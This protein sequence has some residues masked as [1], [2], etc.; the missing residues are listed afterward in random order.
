VDKVVDGTLLERSCGRSAPGTKLWMERSRKK[1]WTKC[2][3]KKLWMEHS[4]KR[5]WM[6][7]EVVEGA[8]G[9]GHVGRP[10]ASQLNPTGQVRPAKGT[11]TLVDHNTAS[12]AESSS[13]RC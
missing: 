2:S 11:V 8:A 1:L 9:P 7:M 6:W 3:R 12:T 10:G 5:L 4:R 13:A